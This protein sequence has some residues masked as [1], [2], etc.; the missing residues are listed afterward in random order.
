MRIE[1]DIKQQVSPGFQLISFRSLRDSTHPHQPLKSHCQ[2][3]ASQSKTSTMFEDWEPELD[4]NH[5]RQFKVQRIGMLLL[6][7]SLLT[8]ERSLLAKQ[9]QYNLLLG[10]AQETGST[11]NVPSI[12]EETV[13][14]TLIVVVLEVV[15]L[16]LLMTGLIV[17]LDLIVRSIPFVAGLFLQQNRAHVLAALGSMVGP[18][19]ACGVFGLRPTQGWISSLGGLPVST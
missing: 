18:A 10:W 13:F 2:E 17:P 15:R 3:S 8:K 5:M 19:S 7:K 6:C 16:L 4:A 14:W 9:R 12:Q 1:V 11:I